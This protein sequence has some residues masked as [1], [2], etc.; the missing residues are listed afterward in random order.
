MNRTVNRATPFVVATW[1]L[2]RCRPG[3]ARAGRL[4][5]WMSRIAADVWILT[6]THR[7]FRPGPGHVLVA[8]SLD[9]RD[10]RAEHGECW[11]ALWSRLPAH[12]VDLEADRERTAAMRLLEQ[13]AVVVGTVLPWLSDGRDQARRGARAFRERLDAQSADWRRLAT[14]SPGGLVVAGDFNQDLLDGG[15]YY[16]SAAGR[17]ALRD[18]LAT[19]GLDG[20]TTGQRNP[21]ERGP[22]LAS[23]DHIFATG[24]A[25]APGTRTVAFPEP[26]TLTPGLTDHY[27]VAATLE[28]GHQQ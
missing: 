6:E 8:A 20:L 13:E 24:L 22:G 1:N 14:A 21:L 18:T 3:S 2:A 5:A 17:R 25:L 27:G 10:R 4:S 11:V 19:C 28:R 26:G 15:H 7:D 16:G 9:A 12:P 23:V